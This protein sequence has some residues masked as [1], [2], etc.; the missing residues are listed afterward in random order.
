MKICLISP[1]KGSGCPPI[2]LVHLGTYIQSLGHRVDIIDYNYH[3][4]QL[5][6]SSYD[7]VGISAM[8]VHYSEAIEIAKKINQPVII[9]GVH[10]T[11]CPESFHPA[12]TSMVTGEGESAFKDLLVDFKAGNLL[13]QYKGKEMV[14]DDMPFPNWDLLDQRYFKP[15]LNTT[16]MEKGIEGWLMTS[17]GCPYKCRFCS[18]TQFWKT[19]RFHSPEYVGQLISNL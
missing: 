5:P 17:R 16:F 18:T 19:I 6:D 1:A 15:R 7:L 2:G 13:K 3:T 9:G 10:I 11:T 14:L 12:F 8:T 4:G